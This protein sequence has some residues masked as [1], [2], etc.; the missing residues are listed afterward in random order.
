MVVAGLPKQNKV[1]KLFHVVNHLPPD[2]LLDNFSAETSRI[3]LCFRSIGTEHHQTVVFAKSLSRLG[4]NVFCNYQVQS[5]L[6]RWHSAMYFVRRT[7][8][9][10]GDCF[11]KADV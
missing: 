2:P 10:R 3:V 9:E 5:T 1:H 4:T 6:A 8:H 11:Y 7:G